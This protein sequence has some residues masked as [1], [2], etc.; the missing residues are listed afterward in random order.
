MPQFEFK[1][2]WV[3]AEGVR[4]PEL[5]ATWASLHITAGDSVVTRVLDTRASTV[6]DFV[7]VPIYPLAEWL[8]P[9]GGFSLTSSAVPPRKD[10]VTS[11]AAT[12]SAPTGKD[13]H[14][15]TWR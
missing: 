15:P 5:C 1:I 9:T 14:F 10:A 12:R 7:Y 3:D 6:R 11:I 4:G 13:M 8:A 2:D